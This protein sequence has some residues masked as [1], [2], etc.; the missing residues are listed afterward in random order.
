[1]HRMSADVSAAIETPCI[2]VCAIDP[3]TGLCLGCGRNLAEI[4]AWPT[5]PPRERRRIMQDLPARRA[6]LEAR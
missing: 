3:G 5:L 4:S 2:K 6:R 1:M